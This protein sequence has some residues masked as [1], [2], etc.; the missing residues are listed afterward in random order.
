MRTSTGTVARLAILSTTGVLF[1]AI[2]TAAQIADSPKPDA[3]QPA[4]VE[5]SPQTPT[6]YLEVLS[7]T[8]GVD[9]GPY[10]SR[11]VQNVRHNWYRAIPEAG[12]W[13]KGRVKIEF[14]ITKDGSVAGMQ[15]FG[16]SGDTALDRAAWGGITTSNPFPPLPAE[17]KGPNLALRL[18]FTYPPD[19]GIAPVK[20]PAG[21]TQNFSVCSSA[22]TWAI[23][24]DQCAKSD[25]GH[26]SPSGLYTA[27]TSLVQPLDIEI[28]ATDTSA[29]FQSYSTH[30]TVAPTASPK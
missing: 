15:L 2:C 25:C 6:P 30:V 14:V 29:P 18:C 28:K 8:M 27:P 19:A 26:I 3:K 9:F 5:R 24:G 22:V 7:D 16:S 10:L 12:N 23:V 11:V 4:A 1:L 17:F 13:K 20:M 21:T